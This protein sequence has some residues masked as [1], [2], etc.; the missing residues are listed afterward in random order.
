MFIDE[1]ASD[2]IIIGKSFPKALRI[3][4]SLRSHVLCSWG[5]AENDVLLRGFHCLKKIR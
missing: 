3:V 2:R 4:E 5:S 1:K